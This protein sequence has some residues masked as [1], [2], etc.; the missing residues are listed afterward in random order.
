MARAI[1][2]VQSVVDE[3]HRSL[4]LDDGSL[5]TAELSPNLPKRLPVEPGA[6]CVVITGR[7]PL[8]RIIYVQQRD[9]EEL[10]DDKDRTTAFPA[11]TRAALCQSSALRPAVYRSRAPGPADGPTPQARSSAPTLKLTDAERSRFE[12]AAREPRPGDT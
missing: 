7:R 3:R 4:K 11:P 9:D 6:R 10:S 8:A 1:A 12:A 2:T 5:V